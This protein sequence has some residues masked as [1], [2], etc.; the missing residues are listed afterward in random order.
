M[1][2]RSLALEAVDPDTQLAVE[3]LTKEFTW[4]AQMPTD[5]PLPKRPAKLLVSHVD[6]Q[7][8]LRGKTN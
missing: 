7:L 4:I 8:Y 3:T 2:F 5:G 1:L 6:V